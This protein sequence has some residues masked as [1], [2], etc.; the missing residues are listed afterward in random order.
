[1][2]NTAL[3][4]IHSILV[5]RNTCVE[6]RYIYVAYLKNAYTYEHYVMIILTVSLYDTAAHTTTG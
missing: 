2:E 3:C 6:G 1:M 4:S 5:E